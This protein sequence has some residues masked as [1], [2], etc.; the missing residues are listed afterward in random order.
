MRI[1][2]SAVI[3]IYISADAESIPAGQGHAEGHREE[4]TERHIEENSLRA[5]RLRL[6]RA[7]KTGLEGGRFR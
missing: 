4:H 5:R 7:G 1:G 3:I 2:F 6:L